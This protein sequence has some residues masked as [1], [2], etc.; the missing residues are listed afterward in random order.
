MIGSAEWMLK[1]GM[2]AFSH[3]EDTIGRSSPHIRNTAN[4]PHP[5]RHFYQFGIASPPENLAPEN[6]MPEAS[7]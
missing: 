7:S 5:I 4:L 1:L 3:G 2:E 6:P